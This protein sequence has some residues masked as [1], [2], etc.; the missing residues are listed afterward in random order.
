[1]KGDASAQQAEAFEM[2]AAAAEAGGRP[3]EAALLLC[4]AI[5]VRWRCHGGDVS[6]LA[7]RAGNGWADCD[8][9]SAQ[10]REAVEGEDSPAVAAALEK[11]ASVLE[12]A[13]K[14]D[15]AEVRRRIG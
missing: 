12:G 2:L 4:K 8:P 3:G 14:V 10:I 1:M 11:L 9:L 7:G 15:E 5:E 6:M 13:G